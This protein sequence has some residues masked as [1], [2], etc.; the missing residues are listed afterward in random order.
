MFYDDP[1]VLEAVE[2]VWR[3]SQPDEPYEFHEE[4]GSIFWHSEIGEYS[5]DRCAEGTYNRVSYILNTDRWP[6][7]TYH[8]HPGLGVWVG[9]REEDAGRGPSEPDIKFVSTLDLPMLIRDPWRLYLV[10]PSTGYDA[11]GFSRKPVLTE[12]RS[13][14]SRYPMPLLW[15]WGNSIL[16]AA[17]PPSLMSEVN[18][19]FDTVAKMM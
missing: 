4:G 18:W 19:Q 12:L 3:E 5:F 11:H 14:P 13:Y 8:T 2:A 6:I 9:D 15:S 1:E 16:N 10:E 17:S 7:A